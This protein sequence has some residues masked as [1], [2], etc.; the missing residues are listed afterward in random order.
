MQVFHFRRIGCRPQKLHLAGLLVAQG[1]GE[2][3]AKREQPF[4]VEFFLLM[5]GHAPLTPMAHAITFFCLRQDHGRLAF[6][7]HGRVVGGI[8][9][10][11]VMAA[12]A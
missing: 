1:Q 10:D 12:A 7:M 4:I 5:R 3:V 8:N 6:V 11:R 9:L 2:L